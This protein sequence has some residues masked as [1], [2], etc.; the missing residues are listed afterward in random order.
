MPAN[1]AKMHT[2]SS[3]IN[4]KSKRDRNH[5]LANFFNIVLKVDSR[6]GRGLK[7]TKPR[8]PQEDRRKN[9]RLQVSNP[10]VTGRPQN[11]ESAFQHKQPTAG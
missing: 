5:P 9:H 11:A 10:S 2:S 6:R 8:F 3:K 7:S 1:Q 4:R